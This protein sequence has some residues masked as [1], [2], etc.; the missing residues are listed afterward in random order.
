MNDKEGIGAALREFAGGE[1]E[2]CAGP[3]EEH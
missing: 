2:E 1:K 3:V